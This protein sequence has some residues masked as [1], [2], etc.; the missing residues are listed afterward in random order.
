[1]AEI[2]CPLNWRHLS[3]EQRLEFQ[4]IAETAKASVQAGIDVELLLI[5]DSLEVVEISDE[6]DKL[7]ES[8]PTLIVRK[9]LPFYRNSRMF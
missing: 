6:K 2:Y 5:G 1:M 8:F 3:L 4:E 9:I 7:G